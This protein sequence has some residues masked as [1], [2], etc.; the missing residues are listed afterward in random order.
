MSEL[1]EAPEPAKRPRRRCVLAAVLA[2]AVPSLTGCVLHGDGAAEALAIDPVT[3]SSIAPF[4]VDPG[5][6]SD[7]EA[8]AR[9]LAAAG[10]G[11]PL[12]WANPETGSNGVITSFSETPQDGAPCLGFRTTRHAYD[13]IAV[14]AG[15]ACQAPDRQWQVTSFERLGR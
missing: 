12:P 13:G 1:T 11:G 2:L 6:V 15:R 14:F 7:E 5:I 3:T 9:S 4:P 8:I 10:T